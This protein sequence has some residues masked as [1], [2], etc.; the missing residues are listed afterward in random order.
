MKGGGLLTFLLPETT[1]RP[2]L[3]SIDEAVEF[4][5]NPKRAQNS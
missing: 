3:N 4:Y 5:K 2:M 1:G